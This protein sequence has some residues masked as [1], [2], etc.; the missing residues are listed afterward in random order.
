MT[1]TEEATAHQ[2]EIAKSEIE[3][4]K[5]WMI[6]SGPDMENTIGWANEIVE[7]D[8]DGKLPDYIPPAQVEAS[9]LIL[10]ES[11]PKDKEVYWKN[12]DANER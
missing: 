8:K 3:K 12:E 6:S 2:A 4:C 1:E 11:K 5:D 10:A 9:K 7:A